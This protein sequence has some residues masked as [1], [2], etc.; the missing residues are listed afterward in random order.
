MDPKEGQR[1]CQVYEKHLATGG[2]K[3]YPWAGNHPAWTDYQKW[4]L[5][6]TPAILARL[7]EV[8]DERDALL[9][10]KANW[11]RRTHPVT[12]AVGRELEDLRAE[13]KRLKIA[14]DLFERNILQENVE[15]LQVDLANAKD[16]LRLKERGW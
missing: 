4:A 12:G 13:N 16:A 15:R 3:S 14:R 8:E 9:H 2:R 10:E 11:T 1:I 6:N 7:I 5:D